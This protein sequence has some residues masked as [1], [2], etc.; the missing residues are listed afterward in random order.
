MPMK[1]V[2]NQKP[3]ARARKLFHAT[4]APGLLAALAVSLFSFQLNAAEDPNAIVGTWTVTDGAMK[5]EIYACQESQYCG[6]IAWMQ[7]PSTPGGQPRVDE[8]NPNPKKR[9]V[10]LM[11]MEIL[12]GLRHENG[13]WVG[14]QIYSVSEGKTY[15]CSVALLD[16]ATLQ[17]QS[18]VGIAALGKMQTW[19]R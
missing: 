8:R 7:E 17:V 2:S 9:S 18:F 5:I 14:G 16:P 10:S 3:R 1:S 4:R 19:T 11:G 12:W 6:R 13:K 15:N